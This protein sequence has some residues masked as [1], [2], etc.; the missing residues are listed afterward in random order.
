MD[1]FCQ[2]KSAEDF[3]AE[4]EEEEAA[5]SK[6]SMC[7]RSSEGKLAS[8]AAYALARTPGARSLMAYVN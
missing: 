7:T 3:A 6:G 1:L 4:E 5:A 2:T 8:M